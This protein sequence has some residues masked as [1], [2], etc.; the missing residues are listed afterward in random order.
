M[1]EVKPVVVVTGIA[2][3]LGQRLL[4]LLK[5]FQ[6]VGVDLHAP[7]DSSNFRFVSMDLG[8]E[9]SC[10][11][12]TAL[13]REVRPLAVVHLAFV[14]DPVR[15]GILELGRMWQINVA[16]TARVMEAITEV[17]RNDAQA[18]G[19]FIH[20]SSVATYGS[21]LPRPATEEAR[22][23]AHTL[24]YA[25]H[26][27]ESDEVVQG[28]APAMVNC[29]VYLL[30]PHI[31]VGAT[32]Q[33][34]M[35]NAFRGTPGRK[36]RLGRR[37]LER[38]KRLPVVLPRGDRYL[39]N[40]L[41]FVHVDDVAR[42]IAHILRI[43]GPA[44]Q[45]LTVLNV[46]SRGEAVSFERCIQLARSKLI[47]VP[48]A[49]AFRMVLEFFWMAGLSDIPPEAAPYMTGQYIMDTSRLIAFLGARHE[50]VIRYTVEE[51]FKDTFG[52]P[53]AAARSA[54]S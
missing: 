1:A 24:P 27:K 54:A 26:K 7:R 49:W 14:L 40:K 25:I 53:H 18:I 45:R 51:A 9:D 44:P 33:N 10:S 23:D 28:R 11:Q 39:R 17:N 13:L 21:D 29:S 3:N 47:R 15:T 19:K 2:G 8:R 16:G 43:Q 38:G 5:D 35:V 50:E 12:L 41:Q 46:A 52:T 32:M 34:Y 42:L 36:G 22:L 48:G 4:P 31:F 37:L 30:R 20:I 6:V